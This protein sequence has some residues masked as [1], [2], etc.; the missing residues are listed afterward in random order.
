MSYFHQ[1]VAR[2]FGEP[3]QGPETGA[4]FCVLENDPQ[5]KRGTKKG[6]EVRGV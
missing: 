4:D 5:K 1:V 6:D 2:F 3:D